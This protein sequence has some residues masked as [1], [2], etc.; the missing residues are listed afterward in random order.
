MKSLLS[1]LT[2]LDTVTM[3]M[4]EKERRK[5]F[6][7]PERGTKLAQKRDQVFRKENFMSQLLTKEDEVLP[8][9]EDHDQV[10]EVTVGRSHSDIK[11]SLLHLLSTEICLNSRMHQNLCIVRSDFR[12]FGPSLSHSTIFAVMKFFGVS[13]K[14]IG[15]FRN[16]LEGQS[17]LKSILYN[18]SN[19]CLA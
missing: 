7:G 6:L 11:Q 14:W 9:Y 15:V 4:G 3:S 19:R 5:Y 12:R 18:N 17:I 1:T 10:D 13:S 2:K 8:G 16:A